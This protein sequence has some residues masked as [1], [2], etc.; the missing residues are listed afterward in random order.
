MT[1]E[2]QRGMVFS[3]G[4]GVPHEITADLDSP[5]VKYLVDFAGLHS[6]GILQSCQLAPNAFRRLR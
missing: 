5:P 6:K 1:I 2:L 4:P 3:Y